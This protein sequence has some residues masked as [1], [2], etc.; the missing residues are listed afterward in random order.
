MRWCY[1]CYFSSSLNYVVDQS[2]FSLAASS[3]SSFVCC[4]LPP[5]SLQLDSLPEFPPRFPVVASASNNSLSFLALFGRIIRYSLADSS[6]FWPHASPSASAQDSF[7]SVCI[8][9][10]STCI[11]IF[12]CGK[13]LGTFLRAVVAICFWK[14]NTIIINLSCKPMLLLF[15]W[16]INR[17]QFIK[18]RTEPEREEVTQ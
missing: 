14:N 4:L 17:G 9:C 3:A 10:S 12:S 11:G 8:C 2:K 7:A 5:K 1:A 15:L 13:Q 6:K 18:L 16:V